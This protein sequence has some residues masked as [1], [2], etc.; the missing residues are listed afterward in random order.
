[1][2]RSYWLNF[3]NSLHETYSAVSGGPPAHPSTDTGGSQAILALRLMRN[4]QMIRQARDSLRRDLAQNSPQEME[5][6][7]EELMRKH[8]LSEHLLGPLTYGLIEAAIR[9]WEI[10]EKRTLGTEPLVF[11]EDQSAAPPPTNGGSSNRPTAVPSGPLASTLSVIFGEWGYASAGWTAG[12]QSQARVSLALFVE[13]CGDRPIDDYTRADGD[14]FRNTR[15]GFPTS[16][17]SRSR[18]ETS[19]SR[20]SSRRLMKRTLNGLVRTP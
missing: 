2:A 14:K 5:E 10:A 4:L 7:A 12:V 11:G 3:N 20:K 17:E 9:G 6:Y 15:G 18:T 1:L 19:R 16:T 8:G 13:V